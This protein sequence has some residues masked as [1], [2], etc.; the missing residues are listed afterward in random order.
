MTTTITLNTKE[1]GPTG[2]EVEINQEGEV[3]NITSAASQLPEM[4]FRITY[5]DRWEFA[6]EHFQQ[7][8]VNLRYRVEAAAWLN[9]ALPEYKLLRRAFRKAFPNARP[10]QEATAPL[11][12]QRAD[13]W[14]TYPAAR[15]AVFLQKK[16]IAGFRSVATLLKQSKVNPNALEPWLFSLINLLDD[17]GDRSEVYHLV[18]LL[19]TASASEFL[20]SELERPGRH[21]Y[22]TGL[23]NAV[24]EL[25]TPENQQ[26]ILEL[27]ASFADDWQQLREYLKVISRL[28]GKEVHQVIITI[29]HRHS[30]LAKEAFAALKSTNHPTPGDAIRKKFDKEESL[31]FFDLI[32]ELIDQEPEEVRVSLADMNAKIDSPTLNVAAPVTWPQML[33]PNWS[34]LVQA[35]PA[36]AIFRTVASYLERSEPWLQ[37]CALLQLDTWLQAQTA[38]PAIP[39]PVE[40][41]MRQLI[42]SRYEKVY[43]IILNIAEKLFDQLAEPELMVDAVLEHARTSGYRLMNAAVLKKAAQDSALKARQIEGLK[44]ALSRASAEELNS[45]KRLIPYVRFLEAGDQLKQLAQE[46]KEALAKAEL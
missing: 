33:G 27:Y 12:A 7:L 6:R 16:V 32:A 36:E 35:A 38:P 42:T 31:F 39:L 5:G 37:R 43:T 3:L 46:R 17:P 28:S 21:P 44:T 1:Y 26:R 45:L 23:L 30:S 18:G 2:F 15:P 14:L 24:Q 25:A 11:H 19:G 9:D 8:A 10:S 29:L 13:F 40:Q 34:K 22:S 41:R 4:V 20:F